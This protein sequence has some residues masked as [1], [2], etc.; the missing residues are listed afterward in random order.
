M[1]KS[2]TIAELAK[3][4]S[5]AQGELKA[6][7]K[8][9]DNPYFHSKYA[10]LATCFETLRPVLSK[11]GLSIVQLPALGTDYV[12]VE[13]VLLHESGEWISCCPASAPKDMGPQ[14][15]GSTI[16]YLRR[17]GLA[18][19]GLVTDADDDGNDAGK[20]EKTPPPRKNREPEPVSSI[21]TGFP[22]NEPISKGMLATIKKA[23]ENDTEL[24]KPKFY[25][26][27]GDKWGV[28]VEEGVAL[29]DTIRKKDF[30]T[31]LA[32]MNKQRE[33]RKKNG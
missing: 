3:A 6:A 22:D 1:Q 18:I 7:P 5:K 23:I 8:D 10:D 13:T 28:Q 11:Y 25:K 9:S 12:D 4:L 24:D 15:V 31:I 19:T 20:P 29:L 33:E 2:D 32:A 30:T 17:Y 21:E 14:A 16:T 26:W 27:L